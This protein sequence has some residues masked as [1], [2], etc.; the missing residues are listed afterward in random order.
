MTSCCCAEFY[1]LP[2]TEFLLGKSFHPGGLT[3][4]KSLTEKLLLSSD[5][6]VLDVAS[7]TGESGLFV[8]EQYAAN[9]DVIDFSEE[10]VIRANQL[11]KQNKLSHL[12][13]ARQGSAENLPFADNHFDAVF[14]ECA[15]CTFDQPQ[16]AMKE[17]YRVLKSHG[18]IGISDIYL[19]K[20]LPASLI[21][22]FSKTLC[23]S[24]ALSIEGYHNLLSNAGFRKIRT[25]NADWAIE[26]I[27]SRI[28][29]QLNLFKL[30]DFKS[31]FELPDEFEGSAQF[32]NEL[33]AFI[34]EEGLGYMVMT[35][36][37]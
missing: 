16:V 11:A 26:E 36:K 25:Q 23:I 10:Q 21:G 24:G 3:L 22:P 34:K 30:L 6:L 19:N 4:T 12:F 37:I 31:D 17:M 33:D 7:G 35:A 8:A 1:Q 5:S 32:F 20:P 29:K 13:K 27:T 9:V 28:Y 14:C 15:V 2:M 18:R